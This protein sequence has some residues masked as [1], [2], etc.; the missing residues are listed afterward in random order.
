M[1]HKQETGTRAFNAVGKDR[2]PGV[3]DWQEGNEPRF[4][5]TSNA[6]FLARVFKGI[7]QE[8]AVLEEVLAD[9]NLGKRML[10]PKVITITT[11]PLSEDVINPQINERMGREVFKQELLSVHLY[12]IAIK[13]VIGFAGLEKCIVPKTDGEEVPIAYRLEVKEESSPSQKVLEGTKNEELERQFAEKM[14]EI[15]AANKLDPATFAP[16]LESLG[17]NENLEWVGKGKPQIEWVSAELTEEEKNEVVALIEELNPKPYD[18]PRPGERED[19]VWGRIWESDGVTSW[20]YIPSAESEPLDLDDEDEAAPFLEV[21][22]W[23]EEGTERPDDVF[24]RYADVFDPHM[25]DTTFVGE[26]IDQG[27]DPK[28]Y[29]FEQKHIDHAN[30]CRKRIG[31]W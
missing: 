17:L 3:K 13:S 9:P 24:K 11:P 12:Q 10:A 15:F 18:I 16:I 27:I 6:E 28:E 1:S 22:D 26:L 31:K 8:S 4:Y 25:I 5:R 19:W 20:H 23:V 7:D 2:T 29:G 21:C 14:V 30:K